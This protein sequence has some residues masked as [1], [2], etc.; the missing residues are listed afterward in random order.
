MCYTAEDTNS[1]FDDMKRKVNE[2][3]FRKVQS[4]LDR[5]ILR[6]CCLCHIVHNSVKT[7]CGCVPLYIEVIVIKVYK[8]FYI[9]TVRVT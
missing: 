3:M 5:P 8:Y 2:N 1:N 9:Y 6:I 7:A 4:D